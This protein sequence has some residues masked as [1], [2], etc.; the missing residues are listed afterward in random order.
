MKKITSPLFLITLIVLVTLL[1]V[2]TYRQ[3][4]PH[5]HATNSRDDEHS[6]MTITLKKTSSCLLPRKLW[7]QGSM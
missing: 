4:I 5:S 7:R 3:W 2:F 1:G 6:Q